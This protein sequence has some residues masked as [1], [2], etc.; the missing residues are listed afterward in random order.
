VAQ[1]GH[2]PLIVLPS[3]IILPQEQH[4]VNPLLAIDS[5]KSIRMSLSNTFSFNKAFFT[6]SEKYLKTNSIFIK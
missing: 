6:K 2:D 1:S 3:D 4:S 5:I